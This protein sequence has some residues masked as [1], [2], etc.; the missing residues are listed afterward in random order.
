MDSVPLGVYF[1]TGFLSQQGSQE[2]IPHQGVDR[3]VQGVLGK[4]LPRVC[5]VA[6]SI[7][8]LHVQAPLTNS[9]KQSRLLLETCFQMA[10]NLTHGQWFSADKMFCNA[11]CPTWAGCVG[12][13]ILPATGMIFFEPKEL[14]Y[15]WK[16]HWNL[17]WN[18]L[19]C[20]RLNRARR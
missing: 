7:L 19:N 15:A 1:S 14:S 20:R 2:I 13:I 12:T 5:T 16:R 17:P 3:W 8:A 4:G 18:L 6:P 10:G 9:Q 11:I